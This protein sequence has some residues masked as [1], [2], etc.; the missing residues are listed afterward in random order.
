LRAEVFDQCVPHEHL[1]EFLILRMVRQN[2][3]YCDETPKTV[4]A[5]VEPAIN[6]RHAAACD[7]LSKDVGFNAHDRPGFQNT[8]VFSAS[9]AENPQTVYRCADSYLKVRPP[10]NSRREL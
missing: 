9:W 5:N 3:F 2:S 7:D 8:E 10:W 4:L 1:G 6:F